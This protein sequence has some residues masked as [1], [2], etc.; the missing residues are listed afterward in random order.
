MFSLFLSNDELLY[1]VLQKQHLAEGYSGLLSR[2]NPNSPNASFQR[3]FLL[4]FESYE[5]YFFKFLFALIRT[6]KLIR[7]E[8]IFVRTSAYRSHWLKTT[9]LVG[10]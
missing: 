4:K 8:K 10:K 6:I 1:T 5:I 9:E 3:R 7:T 2:M